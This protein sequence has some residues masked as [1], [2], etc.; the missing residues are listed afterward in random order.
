MDSQGFSRG[1]GR[2]RMTRTSSFQ[3]YQHH[4][5]SFVPTTPPG[6]PPHLA[7]YMLPE[8]MDNE[9]ETIIPTK[10]TITLN[11]R[12]HKFESVDINNNAPNTKTLN[13]NVNINTV[14]KNVNTNSAYNKLTS[15]NVYNQYKYK[16]KPFQKKAWSACSTKDDDEEDDSC[17]VCDR[18]DKNVFCVTCGHSWKGRMRI[19]CLKHPSTVML[20]D[21]TACPECHS[22]ELKE[23]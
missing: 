14:N 18:S 17:K 2:A 6:T 13:K 16:N 22:A 15:P 7:Q 23:I 9:F 3:Q 4:E 5:P 12:F 1:R 19:K 20:C 8:I 21:S 11:E 10:K